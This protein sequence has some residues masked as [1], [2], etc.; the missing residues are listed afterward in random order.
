M[1]K[2][3]GCTSILAYTITGAMIPKRLYNCAMTDASGFRVTTVF[4]EIRM[5]VSIERKVNSSTIFGAVRQ[6][7]H[8]ADRVINVIGF[9]D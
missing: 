9:C 8:E 7:L 4:Q 5:E 3:T 6:V 2:N 1:P